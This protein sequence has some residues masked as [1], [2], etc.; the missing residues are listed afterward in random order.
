M[1]RVREQAGIAQVRPGSRARRENQMV[2][3]CREHIESNGA[4]ASELGGWLLMVWGRQ[5]FAPFRKC[6]MG[7]KLHVGVPAEGEGTDRVQ[8]L[9]AIEAEI[10]DPARHSATTAHVVERTRMCLSCKVADRCL[11]CNLADETTKARK[12][13]V[14]TDAVFAPSSLREQ[15]QQCACV[16][17]R[18]RACVCVCYI[19]PVPSKEDRRGATLA[20]E[21]GASAN[22]SL[23]L[24]VRAP[25]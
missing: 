6:A 22:G 8:W 3:K 20:R 23:T 17:A 9:A 16:C 15:Q 1:A 12:T 5:W 18:A 7:S 11:S 14:L 4:M 25:Q 21:N 10:T 13:V 19:V 24:P 2:G